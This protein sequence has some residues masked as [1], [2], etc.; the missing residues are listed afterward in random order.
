M[1]EEEKNIQLSS[2]IGG[3]NNKRPYPKLDY[4]ITDFQE[5]SKRV[6][7]ICDNVPPEKLTSYYLE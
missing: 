7:E 6:H 5:R 3:E 2:S 1:G 4:T